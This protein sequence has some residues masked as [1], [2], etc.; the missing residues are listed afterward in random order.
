[1]AITVGE[2]VYKVT[3]DTSGVSKSL[4]DADNNAKKAGGSFSKLKLGAIAVGVAV[5]GAAIALTRMV[6][7][8]LNVIDASAK[9]AD[10]LG[11]SMEAMTGLE[12]IAGLT[13]T[14]A[15]QLGTAMQMLEVKLGQSEEGSGKAESALRQLGLRMKDVASL[16]PDKA[17]FK[18]AESLQAVEDRTQQAYLAQELFGR[19]GRELLGVIRSSGGSLADMSKEA[20][21]LGLTISRSAAAEVEKF[22][23][24]MFRLTQRS[25]GVQRQFTVSLMPALNDL[26]RALLSA[27]ENGGF[28]EKA[29]DAITDAANS[30]IRGITAMIEDINI[31]TGNASEVEKLNEQIRRTAIAINELNT[32]KGRAAGSISEFLG[33][34]NWSDEMARLL[35]QL[36][37]LQTKK[38]Q[39]IKGEEGTKPKPIIPPPPPGKSSTEKELTELEKLKKSAQ[40]YNDNILENRLK[41]ARSILNLANAEGNAQDQA[42]AQ[43]QVRELEE[44]KINKVLQERIAIIN[45]ANMAISAGTNLLQSFGALAQAQGERRLAQLDAQEQRALE[46]AG[47]AEESRIMQLESEIREAEASGNIELANEKK[48]ELKRAQIQEQFEKKRR[49]VEYETALQSWEIQRVLAVAQG[50]Q[51]VLNAYSSAAAIPGVGWKIAPFAAALAGLAAGIQIAAVNASKPQ[52]PAFA[53]GGIVPGTSFSGD[54]ITARVNSGEMVLNGSQQARLFEM[55]NGAGGAGNISVYLGDELIYKNLYKASQRGD[56]IIDARGIVTR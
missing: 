51:A 20:E 11:I 24:N 15:E 8:Q 43:A 50:A 27:S 16:E 36:D 45:N 35:I 17:F 14:S 53:E 21:R 1:M 23:D 44:E 56:L 31:L 9:M 46:A 6:K 38:E 18:V 3:G 54:N 4:K 22:N 19:Q 30:V 10:K 33:G 13:G 42:Y 39:L 52:P 32:I 28:L 25:Q 41:K 34:K 40:E 12:H 7:N 49:Q 37:N 26:G 55:A 2:L 29:L 47:V 48:K 5:G